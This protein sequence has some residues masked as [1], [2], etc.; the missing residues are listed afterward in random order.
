MFRKL[1]RG[2]KKTNKVRAEDEFSVGRGERKTSGNT[3]IA[4]SDSGRTASIDIDNSN[5]NEDFQAAIDRVIKRA[6]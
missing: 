3:T 1:F 2:S 4:I 5:P 6:R